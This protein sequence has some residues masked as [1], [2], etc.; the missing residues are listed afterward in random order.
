MPLK[1]YDKYF[2]GKPGAA[3]EAHAAMVKTY[4]TKKADSIFYA[5]VNRKRK[6]SKQ[7]QARGK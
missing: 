5:L 3:S 2:G 6:L 7:L 4:G 1:V